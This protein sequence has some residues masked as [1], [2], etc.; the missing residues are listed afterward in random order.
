MYR[1]VVSHLKKLWSVASAWLM[2]AGERP[3]TVRIVLS[4]VRQGRLWN[5]KGKLLPN[6]LMLP[7]IWFSGREL[8]TRFLHHSWI[9]SVFSGWQDQIANFKDEPIGKRGSS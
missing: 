2:L 5:S 8:G 4:G 9:G 6:N 1:L 3:N 7:M